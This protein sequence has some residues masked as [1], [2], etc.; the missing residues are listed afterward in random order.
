M[1]T[2]YDGLRFYTGHFTMA[3]RIDMV[4]YEYFTCIYGYFTNRYV[5]FSY[6]YELFTNWGK[7]SKLQIRTLHFQLL[8]FG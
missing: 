1:V 3:L 2:C 5:Y 7:V 6:A 4:Y 8:F